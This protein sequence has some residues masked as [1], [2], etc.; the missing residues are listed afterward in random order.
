MC[1]PENEE[2]LSGGNVSGDVRR[3]GHT[4]RRRAGPWTPAVH[5]LLRHLEQV[6]FGDA[7]R[8]LGIDK[9]GREILT[10]VSGSVLHPRV[11]DDADLARVAR[12]IRDC[13]AA[14]ASFVPPTEAHWQMDSCDPSGVD[15]LICHND[16]APWNLIVG[17]DR[18]VF[19]DWESAA[20]GRR[21][22]D[23]ALAV[24]SFVPLSPSQPADLRRYRLFCDAY[25][26]SAVDQLELL[27]V[28]VERTQ[29]MWRIL[30]DNAGREPYKSMVRDGHAETWRSIAQHVE[31]HVAL[32]GSQLAAP[33]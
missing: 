31:Q 24:C 20:P 16:L 4:V 21:L 12:L 13:H 9:Q 18:W 7:P 32:W 11:L 14:L 22:W 26:L 23:L 19:I 1:S 28:V 27:K 8:A 17:E 25:G 2:L 3:V 33:L 10:F 30:V 15:E 29:R 5:Q 6:G